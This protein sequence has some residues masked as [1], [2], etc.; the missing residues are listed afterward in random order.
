MGMFSE[1]VCGSRLVCRGGRRRRMMMPMRAVDLLQGVHCIIIIHPSHIVI[2]LMGEL[3]RGNRCW[4][5]MRRRGGVSA[6]R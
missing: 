6:N 4:V 1:D 3:G 5:V 2:G